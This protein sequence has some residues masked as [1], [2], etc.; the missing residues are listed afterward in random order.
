VPIDLQVDALSRFVCGKSVRLE[1]G[2]RILSD[3]K[4]YLCTVQSRMT[5]IPRPK[6]SNMVYANAEEIIK[7]LRRL[8]FQSSTYY[9]LVQV[10]AP[11]PATVGIGQS[12][13]VML[14]Q[15]THTI[16]TASS[17]KRDEKRP[18]LILPEV[19]VHMW[20]LTTYW[21]TWPMA[22]SRAAPRR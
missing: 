21:N 4:H 15:N 3:F 1:S 19:P 18:P 7:T 9:T 6:S 2:A 12:S 10:Y 16:T 22:K 11:D 14:D 8:R 13:S 17:V 20:T 5:Q